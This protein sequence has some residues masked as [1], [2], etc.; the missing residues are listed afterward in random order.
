M[1][2]Y[3]YAKNSPNNY[4]DPTGTL[5]VFEWIVI[6]TVIGIG[7]AAYSG[8]HFMERYKE[9]IRDIFNGKLPSWGDIFN[10]S[11]DPLVPPGFPD[12]FPDSNDSEIEPPKE[13]GFC[14]L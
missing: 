9:W 5:S 2:L 6:T 13:K 12:I 7:T 11:I 3:K 14:P 4:V 10:G 8:W 1:N